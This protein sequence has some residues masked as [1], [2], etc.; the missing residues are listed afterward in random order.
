M[1]SEDPI[2]IFLMETKLVV[3]EFDS[4]KEGLNISP[5]LVVSSIR[6]SGG[7][8]LLWKK[9]LSVLVQSFLESHINAIINQ[10]DGSQNWRF[11]GFY[12]NSDT[13][14]REK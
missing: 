10:N 5:G 1:S 3:A 11:M 9:E 8:A 7:L 2:L 4:I 6:R 13:S 12:G 14:R